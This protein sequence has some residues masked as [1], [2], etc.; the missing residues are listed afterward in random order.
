MATSG[1]L[2]LIC[3][4]SPS[5]YRLLDVKHEGC[6]RYDSWGMKRGSIWAGPDRQANRTRALLD[7]RCR[8]DGFSA[9]QALALEG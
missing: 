3:L 4:A 1:A 9:H 7:I 5:Q 6:G 2:K 8:W